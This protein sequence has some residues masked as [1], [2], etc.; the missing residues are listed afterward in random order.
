[1]RPRLLQ[2][3]G[4]KVAIVLAKDWYADRA[5]TIDRLVQLLEG[6]DRLEH[7]GEDEYE[8]EDLSKRSDTEDA[9]A[10][11]LG[12]AISPAES[13]AL[14]ESISAKIDETDLFDGSS[15]VDRESTGTSAVAEEAPAVKKDTRRFEF[16][17]ERSNKFWEITLGGAQH[18]VRYGRIGTSGQTVTKTFANSTAAKRD[19]ERLIRSK[20]AKGYQEK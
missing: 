7:I 20:K 19:Y 4:W 13:S 2:N 1:M 15:A 5:A 14:G 18:T 6:D 10:A 11:S 9:E 8:E 12:L 3:F 16:T 17:S